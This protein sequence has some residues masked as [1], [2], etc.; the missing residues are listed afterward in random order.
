MLSTFLSFVTRCYAVTHSL[1]S[2]GHLYSIHCT[3]FTACIYPDGQSISSSLRIEPFAALFC[4]LGI[5]L[6][7]ILYLNSWPSL[8][9]LTSLNSGTGMVCIRQG[10]AIGSI[11]LNTCL[12]PSFSDLAILFINSQNHNTKI[13]CSLILNSHKK[14]P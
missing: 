8:P 11:W 3:Q 1:F 10:S 9:G 14:L 2:L 4:A 13:I 7:H 6:A 5:A 12:L